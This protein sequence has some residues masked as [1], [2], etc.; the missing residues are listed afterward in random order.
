MSWRDDYYLGSSDY[1]ITGEDENP[2]DTILEDSDLATTLRSDH[3][4]LD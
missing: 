1:P 2:V 4:E 3:P